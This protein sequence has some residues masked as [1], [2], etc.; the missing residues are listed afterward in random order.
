MRSFGRSAALARSPRPTPAWPGADQKAGRSTPRRGRSRSALCA[1]RRKGKGKPLRRRRDTPSFPCASVAHTSSVCAQGVAGPAGPPNGAPSPFVVPSGP[2]RWA[3]AHARH[4]QCPPA[5]AQPIVRGK[6]LRPLLRRR[7]SPPL[8]PPRPTVG[9]PLP[10]RSRQP[11]SPASGA[12][13]APRRGGFRAGLR[14]VAPG[15]VG[16]PPAVLRPGLLPLVLRSL[17]SPAP[18]GCASRPGFPPPSRARGLPRAPS[19]CA[20]LRP[21]GSSPPCRRFGLP[22]VAPCQGRLRRR[23][24]RSRLGKRALWSACQP[25]LNP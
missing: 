11:G 3:P 4:G 17:R 14:A 6:G 13:F 23:L 9:G 10:R 25:P 8:P 12:G 7:G 1:C 21:P 18:S 22:M 2:L 16:A 20:V 24:W 5:L 15:V 19:G